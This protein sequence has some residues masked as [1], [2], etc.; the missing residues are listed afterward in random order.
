MPKWVEIA[1][2]FAS[3]WN[4]AH[5]TGTIDGKHVQVVVVVVVVVIVV[6]VVVQ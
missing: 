6:V 2:R 4:F 1:H 3:K 5:C